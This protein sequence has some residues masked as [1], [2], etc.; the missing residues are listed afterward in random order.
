L[1]GFEV[2]DVEEEGF[3]DF[4]LE[5]ADVEGFEAEGVDFD[6]LEVEAAVA[7]GFEVVDVGLEDFEV[8][9]KV[10]DGFEAEAVGFEVVVLDDRLRCERDGAS[11]KRPSGSAIVN[12]MWSSI[13]GG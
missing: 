1:A 9:A 5:A 10:V 4:E 8:E 11:L 3:E 7:E 2:C 13:K 6:D 12:S